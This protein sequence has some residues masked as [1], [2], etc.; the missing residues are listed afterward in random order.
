MYWRTRKVKTAT[1]NKNSKG[2][3]CSVGN[4]LSSI[5]VLGHKSEN[6]WKYSRIKVN[7]ALLQ[8]I[9]K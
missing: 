3:V 1:W 6:S 5:D 4:F 2:K 7:E 8:T 9:A